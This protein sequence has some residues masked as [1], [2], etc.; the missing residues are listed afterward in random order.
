MHV[1]DSWSRSGQVKEL[2]R[3]LDGAKTCEKKNEK[4]LQSDHVRRHTSSVE[5]ESERKRRAR[6][7]KRKSERE[8][9][10]ESE[11]EREKARERKR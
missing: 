6:A 9:E 3:H 11:R 2:R 1:R 7:R 10:K 8:C 5:E 4:Q